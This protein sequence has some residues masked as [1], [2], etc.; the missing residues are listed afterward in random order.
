[1]KNP[2]QVEKTQNAKNWMFKIMVPGPAG[3]G[4]TALVEK[5]CSGSL[6]TDHKKTDFFMQGVTI[7]ARESCQLQIHIVRFPSSLSDYCRAAAGAL[8][9]FDITNKE[10][11]LELPTWLKP[12][13]EEASLIPIILVGTKWDLPKREVNLQTA[14][15]YAKSTKCEVRTVFRS[16]KENI[17]LTQ[18][19]DAIAKWA[20]YQTRQSINT[21]KSY[22]I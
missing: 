13:K 7:N 3:V 5:F 1:M 19:F 16:A 6:S 17:N 2:D 15:Q 11:F 20:V 8:L 12:I 10:T 14:A 22:I 9:C 4:K 18:I 21:Q